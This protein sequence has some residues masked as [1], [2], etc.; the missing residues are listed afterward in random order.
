[1]TV[2]PNGALAGDRLPLIVI[3]HGTGGSAAGHADTAIALA[4]AGFVVAAVTHTGDN[5]LDHS[6]SFT[7]QN[8]IGRPRHLSRLIDYMLASWPEHARLDPARIGAFG[9]SA[10]GF[11]VL[12]AAGGIADFA[13]A[14]Q[15]CGDHPE[16]WDCGQ[17]QVRAANSAPP[18]GPTAVGPAHDARIKAAAVAAPAVVYTVPPQGLVAVTIPV[19]VWSAGKDVIAPP[20][21]NADILRTALPSA[22][23]FHAVAEAGHFDYLAPCTDALAKV[24]PPEICAEP[25][26]FDRAAFHRDFNR[27]LV[28][29]FRTRLPPGR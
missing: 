8:F 27:A 24:A 20:Q 10:G 15:F 19:Q 29:F 11:T 26:G 12:I 3:S 13:R 16:L 18:S 7:L 21:W 9:H 14:R 28:E 4:E 25:P 23:D 22:P 6:Y 17:A 1:M 2:A 5:Y